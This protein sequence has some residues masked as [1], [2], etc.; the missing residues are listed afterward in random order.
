M[1]T[2]EGA[3]QGNVHVQAAALLLLAWY[4]DLGKGVAS[5]LRLLCGFKRGATRPWSAVVRARPQEEFLQPQLSEV[6]F[7]SLAGCCT[8][9]RN[10]SA[11]FE[12]AAS[13]L[14]PT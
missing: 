11:N 1:C 12:C 6:S 4:D 8:K 2:E 10:E 7:I 5:A 9:Q 13:T 3:K 14:V